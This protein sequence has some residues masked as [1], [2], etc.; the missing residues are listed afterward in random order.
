MAW[1]GLYFDRCDDCSFNVP[2]HLLAPCGG[3][4]GQLQICPDCMTRCATC[5]RRYY[6]GICAE[7]QN[8]TCGS[9]IPSSAG[10]SASSAHAS[11]A[12]LP[13]RS[14]IASSGAASS[15]SAHTRQ[16]LGS[17]GSGSSPHSGPSPTGQRG[18]TTVYYIPGFSSSGSGGSPH[19]GS[20]AASRGDSATPATSQEFFSAESGSQPRAQ[21]AGPG[22]NLTAGGHLERWEVLPARLL[23]LGAAARL[24]DRRPEPLIRMPPRQLEELPAVAMPHLAAR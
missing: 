22:P 17:F 21:T 10:A 24:Q 2:W 23:A 15:G 6:C 14:G 5:N 8:H 19:T 1:A 7:P 20:I 3:T 13:S 16:G 4:C 18:S 12:T 11:V 9:W